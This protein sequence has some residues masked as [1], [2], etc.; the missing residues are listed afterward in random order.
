[1]S[2]Q[3]RDIVRVMIGRVESRAQ[4]PGTKDS[5]SIGGL[6]TRQIK[7]VQPGMVNQ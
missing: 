7:M 6:S 3:T 1:M 5:S 4:R 2:F